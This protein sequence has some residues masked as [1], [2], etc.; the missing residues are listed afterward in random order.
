MIAEEYELFVGEA[1]KIQKSSRVQE[2]KGGVGGWGALHSSVS[3]H[4][5]QF[6]SARANL[7]VKL[8]CALCETLG[9]FLRPLT[10]VTCLETWQWATV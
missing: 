5:F 3:V 8:L 6:I 2:I 4:K 7:V 9:D 10:V 1:F